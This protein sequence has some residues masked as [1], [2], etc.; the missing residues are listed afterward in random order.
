M[1]FRQ[2]SS[3]V[4]VLLS[5]LLMLMPGCTAVS[6]Y[7]SN[8]NNTAGL[9]RV[10]GTYGNDI[11]TVC[12]TFNDNAATIAC[13]SFGLPGYVGRVIDATPFGVGY[14]PIAMSNVQCPSPFLS[15]IN[16]CTN[17]SAA[18]TTCGHSQ[19][20]AISCSLPTLGTAGGTLT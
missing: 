6:Y 12:G 20:V 1:T 7:L 9:L 10:L 13:S 14:G 2:R 18:N 4:V 3:Y 11:G 16:N 15:T 19:D 5:C 17:T 8:G